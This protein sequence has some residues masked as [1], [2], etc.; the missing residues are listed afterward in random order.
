MQTKLQGGSQH[1]LVGLNCAVSAFTTVSR[2]R[3]SGHPN[4]SMH[5]HAYMLQAIELALEQAGSAAAET[6]IFLDDSTRNII[7]G[8]QKGLTTVLVRHDT[9]HSCPFA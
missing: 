5:I 7:A 3:E 4:H 6:T 9:N 2:D 1:L 8:R